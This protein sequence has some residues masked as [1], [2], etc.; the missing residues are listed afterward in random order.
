[1]SF[2]KSHVHGVCICASISALDKNRFLPVMAPAALEG[3]RLSQSRFIQAF[4]S[5][6]GQGKWNRE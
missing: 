6:L 4:L 3:A 1:M 2:L 5:T